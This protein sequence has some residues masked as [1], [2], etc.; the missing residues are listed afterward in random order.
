MAHNVKQVH[1]FQSS[2]YVDGGITSGAAANTVAF[3]H[4][5][6][7]NQTFWYACEPHISMKMHGEIIVGDGGVDPTSD[8]KESE[9]APGFIAPTMLLAILGAVLFMGRRRSL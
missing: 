6:T 5:F 2:T 1:G 9:D 3:H 8:K 4:T 7:E